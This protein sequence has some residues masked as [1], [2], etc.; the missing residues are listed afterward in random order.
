MEKNV[1]L[2]AVRFGPFEADLRAGELRKHGV[3]LK[4][5]GQPFE[6]LAMLL[7]S[8]GQLVTREELRTRLW[9]TDTFVDFDH[10]L[11]AAVNKLRDALSES[12][13]KP[14]YV[15]TLPRRG[16]RFISAVDLPD[17]LGL[18]LPVPEM[19]A[20][21]ESPVVVAETQIPSRYGRRRVFVT[22]LV[23]VVI[24]AV[25]FGFD[26]GGVRHRLVGA[27]SVPRIQ[28]IAVLPLENLSKDPEQEYFADG[29]TDELITNLAQ[30]SALRVISRTSAM[31]YKGTKKSLSEIAREL[32]VDAVVEGTV[33][34]S[35]DRVRITAQLIEASTDH[36]LWAA[37]YDRDLQNVLSMQ[38]EVTRA[39][40]S[41]VRVKLTAQEQARLANMHPINPEA[42]QL[43]LKGRYYWYKL[44]PEGLQKAIEYFQQALEKDPAYA[45]AYAGLADSYNLL[46][47]FNVFPPREVMPKAKAAA[48][49]ALELDDNL[50]EAHVSL[51]WAG[52]TYDLDWPAAGK[53]FDRAIVL[54]PAYPLAHSYYSLYLGALGRSEEGL[55]EAKRALDLD[56]VSPAINHYVVVQLY[57][58]R[59]F[60][61][62]IEQCRK[63]LE[64]DPS[65]T[66]VHGTLAEVYS[67]KGMYREALAEYEEYSA[68]SGGSPRS[69]A[70]VGYAH[71]RLGQRSQAFRVLEQLRAA[72]KQKYVPALSFAIVYVGL[73]E[74]EQAFLWLEKAYDERTNSLA[75]LKVQATWDPLRSDPRFADLVRR[76][77]LPP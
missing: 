20:S 63:T 70:F 39:I 16:Y 15:E 21:L 53:H 6:V 26:L 7:E 17:S 40:V 5:V 44:N 22:A 13:E 27:P 38:E 33:M 18:K 31:Q 77:G 62:A 34:H 57:L 25:V 58:A 54:N 2:K 68:L 59:R 60:D 66:A 4:L 12:A 43:W 46:A 75:Y 3:K 35:G 11:N 32:H 23:L 41:E 64:L 24:L 67:A 76:I 51:G 69:T 8:P 14:T 28:S 48:V 71:A 47:F 50:A 42:F 49:K 56:P 52:F 61:E 36:H 1:S 72:S 9:P 73:G 74:K 55:T 37:S 10:G 65:F 30:I 29:M 45:P 19:P